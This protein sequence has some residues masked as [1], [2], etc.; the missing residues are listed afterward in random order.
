M[1]TKFNK[2]PLKKSYFKEAMKHFREECET[3]KIAFL[4]VSDDMDWGKTELAKV[5][6]KHKDIFFV[7]VGKEET[8][9]IGFDLATMAS[10]DHTIISRGSFS[11]WCAILAGGE[12]YAEYGP[13]VTLTQL[14]DQQDKSVKRKK[15]K[16]KKHK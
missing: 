8:E 6:K 10:C 2:K 15:S 5:Q 3:E 14:I 13:I 12:Y 16:K 7:G 9:A 11:T 1:K 4:Y